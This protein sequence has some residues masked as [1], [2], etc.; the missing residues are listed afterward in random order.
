LTVDVDIAISSAFFTVT[1]QTASAF[2][3]DSA[4]A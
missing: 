2:S 1:I 4:A 3:F